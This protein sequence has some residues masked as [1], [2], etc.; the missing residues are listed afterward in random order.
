MYIQSGHVT[1]VKSHFADNTARSYGN[2]I[3]TAPPVIIINTT[4]SSN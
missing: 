3:W 2:D 4:F 1:I